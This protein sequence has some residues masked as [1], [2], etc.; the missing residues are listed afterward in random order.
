MLFEREDWKLFRMI[1]TLPQKAGVSKRKLS[2]LVCKELTDNALDVCGS[3]EIGF[4]GEFF[5]VK[6]Q[7]P[8]MDPGLFSISRPLRSSKYLR[9][10]T[11]G[12]LGNGLRVV[13]GAV[14]ATGGQLWVS[15]RGKHY[16]ITLQNDGS[17]LTECLGDYDEAGTK[18]RLTLGSLAIDPIWAEWAIAYAKGETYQGK[19]SPYWYTSE[20]FFELF[21]AFDGTVRD[22]IGQFDGCSGSKAGKLAQNHSHT[23]ARTL[24]FTETEALLS[25]MKGAVK[26]VKPER[27]GR[28]GS[29][30]GWS[31]YV[32]SSGVFRV[33][34]ARGIHNGEIPYVIET[35][36]SLADEPGITVLLNKSPMTG[37]M[38]ISHSK[39]VL[40]LYGRGIFLSMRA[41]PVRLLI[42]I[43]TPYIPI[44]N[45]GKEPDLSVIAAGIKEGVKKV[46][47]RI[48]KSL[49]VVPVEKRSQKDVVAGCLEQA[50][51]KASGNGQYRFSLRQLYYAVRPY[52]IKELEKELDYAYFCKELIG[53]YEAEKGDIPLMY[54][55][56]RGTLY[57]PHEGRD[58]PIG[59]IA[60]EN[61][62]K[63]KWMFN[64]VLYIEKEGF[65]NV[66]K[67]EKIP[68][69]YDMALLTSKGYAS[70][71][72]KDLLDEIGDDAQE[73]ITFFCIHDADAYGT[74]IYETLQNETRARP[75]RKVKIINLGLEP[76]EAIA[77]GL[78]IERVEKSNR[79]KAVAGYVDPVYERWLQN[80][81]VELN[82]MS[83]PL[84]IAWLERKLRP[85]D[86]GKV[87]PPERVMVESLDHS[88]KDKLG[89][90]IREELFRQ[91]NYEGQVAAAFRQVK[92]SCGD[93]Q[94]RLAETVETGLEREPVS[95]W[96]DVVEAVSDEILKNADFDFRFS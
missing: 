41:K 19:T 94:G 33:G 46:V 25:E 86:K 44:V 17:A 61:Y 12:A 31:S 21:Q 91:N 83:T 16:K 96:Q 26:Q 58:I 24:S 53:G 1:E 15:T 85:Y 93:R 71:A 62:T 57:H 69:K 95:R 22:L 82:A 39:G 92:Q 49:P 68:E 10:P 74:T 3:C 13:A 88:L 6:D 32:K 54:R 40:M 9:L 50:I 89:Q 76:E 52:V 66:L 65:F 64:K 51:A 47:A 23:S 84:F 79:K 75:G 42:N 18:I 11:R 78:E 77:M 38:T 70:R 56:E 87:I 5:Y 8:G 20:A 45:D 43:V 36:A 7:G 72:I 14:A 55:D 48:S 80:F 27:L 29:L 60:V 37:E 35:Y 59:T 73:E 2:M 67:A 81:R 63:P 28:I 90:K 4:E 34:T 30:D